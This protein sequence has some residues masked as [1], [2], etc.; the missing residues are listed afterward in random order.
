MNID[1]VKLPCKENGYRFVLGEKPFKSMDE[2]LAY[3]EEKEKREERQARRKLTI[4]AITRDGKKTTVTGIHAGNGRILCAP[5]L[6]DGKF[7]GDPD[8]YFDS[9]ETDRILGEFLR[10]VDELHAVKSSLESRKIT[11]M[12][13]GYERFEKIGHEEAIRRIEQRQKLLAS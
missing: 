5:D 9:P 6:K 3:A 12:T 7:G 4:P 10:L 2:A 8:L 1:D 13:N 11:W